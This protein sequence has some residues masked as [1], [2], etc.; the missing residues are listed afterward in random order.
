MKT[1]KLCFGKLEPKSDI[2]TLMMRDYTT[3]QLSPPPLTF[4]N[5]M[6]VCNKLN[7][8]VPVLFPMDGN[9]R[10]GDC[11]IA[12]I[13]HALT[14]YN[15]LVGDLK[16]PTQGKVVR[17]YK[18]LTGGVDSG[19]VELD[20]LNYWRKRAFNGHKILAYVKIDPKNHTNV[21]QAI[22]L[23]GGVY[24]GF[25]VQSEAI[26]DFRARRVWTPGTGVE[27]GHAVFATSYDEATVTVLTWGNDQ[28][29]TWEWWDDR[30]DEA[31][32]ILPI[33]A[34]EP[35]FAP[36][37]DFAQLKEDLMVVTKTI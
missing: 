31:Y 29:G 30:V 22:R 33:E 5:L 24:L 9:D 27:G 35:G 14:V 4:D 19:L 36:G 17:L 10:W 15:G 32:A 37:F 20:V 1:E 25:E 13:A 8:T 12:G 21:K 7:K 2:R 3:P 6:A 28:R 26:A 18:R 16:I 23:F 34:Q 11:T